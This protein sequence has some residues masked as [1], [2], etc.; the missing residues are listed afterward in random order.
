MTAAETFAS[1]NLI[2]SVM[3][4]DILAEPGFA[5]DLPDMISGGT[6]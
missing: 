1:T 2:I 3:L 5:P 4:S 6:G